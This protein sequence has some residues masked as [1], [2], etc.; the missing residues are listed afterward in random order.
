MRSFA[1]EDD[2]LLASCRKFNMLSLPGTLIVEA[3][4]TF[5]GDS[6]GESRN[7]TCRNVEK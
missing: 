3:N 1:N 4:R 7:N 5:S 2:I 6:T